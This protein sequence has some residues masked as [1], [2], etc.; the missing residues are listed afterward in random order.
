MTGGFGASARRERRTAA[1]LAMASAVAATIA[2]CAVTPARVLAAG[3]DGTVV[4]TDKGKVRGVQRDGYREFLGI[5]FAAPPTG[6]RRWTAPAAH[7]RWSGVREATAPGDR[8]AQNSSSTGTPASYAEDCLYL[9]VTAP[10]SASSGRTK[11]VMVWLHGGGFVEGSGGEYDPRRLAVLGDVVVVTVN[12]R[13]GVFGNFGHPELDGSGSFGLQDQQAALR[14]VRRN[15]RAFGGDP[16]NVTLFGQSAGG[17]SV[18]A[19]LSSPQA[20]GL[21]DRA[22]VQSSFCTRDIPANLL[23]PGLPNVPPWEGPE[24]LASRGQQAAAELGCDAPSTALDCLRRLPTARLMK[25]FGQFAGLS[26]GSRTLPDNPHLAFR[27]GKFAK[28]PVLSGTTRDETTYIQA[29][30][31]LAAGP[32]TAALYRQYLVRAFGRRAVEVAARYPLRQGRPPSRTWAAV[33]TD[34]GL[35]C[36]TLERNRVMSRFVPTYAYEFADRT[37]PPVLP[38]VGYPYGAYHSADAFYLFDVRPPAKQPKLDLAQRRLSD[39][40][41]R[42]WTNFARTGDPNGKDLPRWEEFRAGAQSENIRS[43]TT[44]LPLPKPVDFSREH[45]CD[46]WL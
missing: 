14:W 30:N 16:H 35:A 23:A 20:A 40:M 41:I 33:T 7:T 36:P 1:G 11:P 34:S 8:C 9:N 18:C 26:Y 10:D 21:F 28:I 2:A 6:N 3:D 32:L 45:K 46:F 43:L 39:A 12:Y 5:P 15:A 19:H 29:I 27:T 22:I 17:Q 24:S 38:D 25:I 4:P 13:L 37:A 31:D 42:Y 44:E